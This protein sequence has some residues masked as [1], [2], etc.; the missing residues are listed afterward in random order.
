M[1]II[2]GSADLLK[3]TPLD[4]KQAEYVNTIIAG[5]DTLLALFD[6]ILKLASIEKGE[7]A[8][9][10]TEFRPREIVG[11]VGRLFHG[12]A[13]AAG[14]DMQSDAQADIDCVVRGDPSLLV[15]ILSNLLDN[16]RR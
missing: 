9:T 4:A 12:Q 8:A 7:F 11:K 14:L 16:A 6:N 3:Q 5:G 10:E 2:M 13:R 1:N 15:L